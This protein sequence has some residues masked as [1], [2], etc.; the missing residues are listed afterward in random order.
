MIVTTT[1]TTTAKQTL[2]TTTK[3]I[4][5]ASTWFDKP[6]N[7]TIPPL[8]EIHLILYTLNGTIVS[9]NLTNHS[10]PSEVWRE[11]LSAINLAC[12]KSIQLTEPAAFSAQ[13]HH[14]SSGFSSTNTWPVPVMDSRLYS[15]SFCWT[16]FDVVC[17]FEEFDLKA[18]GSATDGTKI[19]NF[20][21]LKC[22]EN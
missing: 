8:L 10:E 18:V 5:Y 4:F 15:L 6:D 11:N 1:I 20:V 7:T 13:M 14:S 2:F 21:M 12:I 3:S 17:P 19:D 22:R 16:S 9:H